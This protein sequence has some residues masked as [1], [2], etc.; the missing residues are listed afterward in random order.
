MLPAVSY[1]P[2]RT[3]TGASTDARVCCYQ[4]E[5][6]ARAQVCTANLPGAPK[7]MLQILLPAPVLAAT[8]TTTDPGITCRHGSGHH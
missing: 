4:M 7:F 8:S 1:V 5:K 3:R 2:R 6:T